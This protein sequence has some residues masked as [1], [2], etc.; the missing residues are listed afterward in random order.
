[1]QT[2]EYTTIDKTDWEDGEWKQEPDKKQWLDDETK[3]PCLIVRGPAGSLC[4]YVGVSEGHPA[5]EKEYI[6]VDINVEVH[7]GVTFTRFCQH[8]EDPSEGICHLVETGENDKVWWIGFDT[9]H[10]W[11]YSPNMIPMHLRK[12]IG[13][14]R[15][16]DEIYRNFDYVT[17]EVLSLAKQ[18]KAAA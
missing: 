6:D 11:D 17:R 18:L 16:P 5:F 9:A 8:H 3:L 13:F 1:M 10:A 14:P 2:L 4:G 12:K 15:R 7:G